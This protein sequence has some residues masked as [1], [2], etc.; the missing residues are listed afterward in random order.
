MSNMHVLDPLWITKGNHGIDPEYTKYILLA[1][2]QKYRK[3]LEDGDTSDFYE[4]LFHALNLNNLAIEGSMFKFNLTP[5]WDDLKLT[6]IREHLRQ[7]YQ[8]PEDLVEIFKSANY[9]LTGLMLDYL[10]CMLDLLDYTESF[11]KNPGLHR[12]REIFIILN[13]KGDMD[14]DIWKLRNDR[15]FKFGHKH[16]HIKTITL[17][18]I[19]ENAIHDAIEKDGDP[20]LMSMNPDK[21]VLFV[22]M[23]DNMD[24]D[25]LVSAVVSTLTFSR[26]ITKG[27]N[28]EPSIL[29]E[30]HM[31]LSQERVLPFTMKSLI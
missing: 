14:Y 20:R 23:N 31:I 15:R 5:V 12:E 21:N 19:R 1:A 29:S 9:L 3:H 26:G 18:E 10:D 8:M 22:V 11:F 30:L 13:N 27:V 6:E 4:I 2:N 17:E 7:L 24:N 28:F 25:K 16:E